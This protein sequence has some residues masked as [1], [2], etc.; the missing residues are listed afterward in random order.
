MAPV[1]QVPAR[2][3]RGQRCVSIVRCR[4]PDR[5]IVRGSITYLPSIR[6]ITL[7][8]ALPQTIPRSERRPRTAHDAATTAA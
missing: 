2:T 7:V 6:D 1:L 5:K 4:H 8:E 3:H